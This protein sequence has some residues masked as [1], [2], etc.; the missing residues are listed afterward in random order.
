MENLNE[1]VA[2]KSTNKSKSKCNKE[3][4]NFRTKNQFRGRLYFFVKIIFHSALIAFLMTSSFHS[5]C[6]KDDDKRYILY[7]TLICGLPFII[8]LNPKVTDWLINTNTFTVNYT[9]V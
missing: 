7:M 5:Y 9:A 8:F 1:K 4:K 6:M 3:K 2:K